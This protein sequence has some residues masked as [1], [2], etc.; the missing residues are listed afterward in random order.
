MEIDWPRTLAAGGLTAAIGVAIYMAD[1]IQAW[2][3]G[4]EGTGVVPLIGIAAGVLAGLLV[5]NTFLV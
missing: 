1:T 5:A 2:R 4:E 3:L